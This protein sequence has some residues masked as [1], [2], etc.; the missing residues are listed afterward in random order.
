[1]PRRRGACRRSPYAR[2][3]P[4]GGSSP[5]SHAGCAARSSATATA[6]CT[7]RRS[8]GS[9]T[10]P[11]S[12]SRPRATTTARGSRTRSRSSGSRARS[13]ARC[14][15]TRTSPR[16]SGSGTTSATHRS[17]T[18]ARRR[19]T[20]A[21]RERC[22]RG[23][24]HNEH[25]LRVVDVLER[26]GRG[27]NLTHEVRDGI[28]NHTGPVTPES[29]EGRIVKLVDRVAYINH[30][31]DDALRAGVL[32]ASELPEGPVAMLGA[33]GSARID[34]IVHDLVETSE[35]AGDIRQSVPVAEA[36]LALRAFLFERVYGRGP[37]HEE[38]ERAGFVVRSL[39]DHFCAHPEDMGERR[40]GR[41]RAH[42]R[43]RPRG[44][45]DR[46]LRAASLRGTAAAAR[47]GGAMSGRLTPAS[48]DEVRE[49]ADIVE[50]VRADTE[51]R[52]AGIEW[53]GRCPFHQ[54]RTGVVLC[55][56]RQEVLPLLRLRSRRRRFRLRH[57]TT[58]ARFR[59]RR[60]VAGRA[61][62]RDARVRGGEPRDRGA[63][64]RRRSSPRAP[65]ADRGVLSPRPP[66]ES[67]GRRSAH[68]PHGARRDVGEH[69][70][71][72]ARLLARRAPGHR[73][74]TRPRVR[75]TASS[76][77]QESRDVAAEARSIAWR[78]A[79]SSPSSTR[80]GGRSRSRAGEC[81]ATSPARSTSTR[82]RA[83]SGRRAR[84]CTDCTSHA[85]RSRRRR[86]RSSSRAI[87]T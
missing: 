46:S 72:P 29:L 11:R 79:S 69:G 70:A 71:L 32:G 67:A 2:R 45:H 6:P 15:S 1:M 51:L 68:V 40:R 14:A 42:A 66:P 60:G 12:S 10:R 13:R 65:R 76:T 25:S 3:R 56:S 58:R 5:R 28:L 8:A 39:F 4:A 81:P 53:V 52:K 27:L 31:I 16:R 85:R 41:R 80:A 64:A 75:R 35:V 36:M 37:L 9:C 48:K 54:E 62:Q 61:V 78:V 44:R 34:A 73:R 26:D 74:R 50:L 49:R 63:A 38:A 23:F 57:A 22:D 33:T 24:R 84:R 20:R 83:P 21:L 18:P 82:P 77:R 17:A 87:P 19:S 47:P 59:G 86:R 43:D 7:A 30:D 55:Q